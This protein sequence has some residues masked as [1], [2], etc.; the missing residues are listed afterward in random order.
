MAS[1]TVTATGCSTSPRSWCSP[2]SA[3]STR[4]SSRRSR[5]RPRRCARSRPRTVN[6]ARSEAARLIASHTPERAR[7]GLLHQRRRRR[8]RARRPDGAAAHRSAQGALDATAATTA[9]PSS[10]STSPATRGGGPTTTASTGTVHFFGPF[11]YRSAFHGAP[12]RRRSASA[13]SRTSSRSSPSRGRRR[14]PRSCWSPSPAR[15]GSWSRRRATSRGVRELC[16]R[17][18]IVLV[19]DEVMS[20]FGRAGRWFALRARP[21]WCP[22]C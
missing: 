6:A 15:P 10:R 5:S 9:A 20:G 13:R 2:T 1:G 11:L 22:T 18:G 16:D 19:A 14:S 4:G 12:P 7:P 17:H 3:T 8:Q 21:A